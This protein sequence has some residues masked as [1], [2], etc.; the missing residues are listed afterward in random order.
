MAVYNSFIITNEGKKQYA[1]AIGGAI[2]TF[3]RAKLG[4]GSPAVD[5]ESLTDIVE[6]SAEAPITDIDTES[7]A[8]VARITIEL[9]NEGIDTPIRIREIGVY[10]RNSADNTESL[11]AYA[12]SDTDIDVIPSSSYGISTW[13]MT[14]SLG[15]VN[16]TAE[17]GGGVV[18]PEGGS[19]TVFAAFTPTV[20]VTPSEG[21]VSGVKIDECRYSKVNGLVTAFYNIRGN[22]EGMEASTSG[23]KAFS[24]ALPHGATIPAP[25]LLNLTVT[26]SAGTEVVVDAAAK[27]DPARGVIDIQF[28]GVTNGA[29]TLTALA[30]YI[31]T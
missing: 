9:S 7:V 20:T 25:V 30:Q 10:C 13:K 12:S 26:D 19:T 8:G 14:I 22:L 16:T 5:P 28:F 31:G 2:L 21:F 27:V 15:V 6:L 4:S 23:E 24:V 1:K 29:F 3:T 18:I 17:T 11:Y